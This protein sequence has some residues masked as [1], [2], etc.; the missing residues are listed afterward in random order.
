MHASMKWILKWND[1]LSLNFKLWENHETPRQNKSMSTCLWTVKILIKML[2]FTFGSFRSSL[3]LICS[4][5]FLLSSSPCRESPYRVEACFG[6]FGF[7]LAT[8]AVCGS[9]NCWTRK[10]ANCGLG[11]FSFPL[12]CR[13]VVCGP[14]GIRGQ[15]TK[16]TVSPTVYSLPYSSGRKRVMENIGWVLFGYEDS[17][18]YS[19][20][21]F[22]EAININ[23]EHQPIY[24]SI[25]FYDWPAD[26]T[27]R[28]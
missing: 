19:T 10:Q 22:L 2:A 25:Y 21:A 3:S 24:F 15:D 28:W 14:I 26:F 17:E 27:Y 18:Y 11:G 23:I 1:S 9:G 5:R 12:S 7:G 20:C 8:A 13:L 16:F 6:V 4:H